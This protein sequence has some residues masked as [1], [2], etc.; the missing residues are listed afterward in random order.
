[1]MLPRSSSKATAGCS[2]SGLLSPPMSGDHTRS[3]NRK[4]EASTFQ[5]VGAKV[6]HDLRGE[7][8]GKKER[9][10]RSLPRQLCIRYDRNL[11]ARS[12]AADLQGG[13]LGR[14]IKY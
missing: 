1:M 9:I 12:G 7:V 11:R 5:G 8:P 4:D 13:F 14:E 2:S 3:G 10:V 6:L